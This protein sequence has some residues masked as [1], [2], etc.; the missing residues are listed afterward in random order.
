[1]ADAASVT[2][3]ATILP[4][5]IAKTLTGTMSVSPDDANDKWYYKLTA[6]TTTSAEE[7][8]GHTTISV[9]DATVF[10]IG[11]LVNFFFKMKVKIMLNALII[12]SVRKLLEFSRHLK[13]SLKKEAALMIEHQ[14]QVIQFNGTKITK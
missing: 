11:D 10:S 1:M 5:E 8:S 4:D 14:N 6:V 13:L 3:Q 2:I 9:T 12:I 7:S